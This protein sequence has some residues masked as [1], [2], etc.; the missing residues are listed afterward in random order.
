MYPT[1]AQHAELP[2]SL[3]LLKSPDWQTTI[4][5][6]PI[7]T[8]AVN[9]NLVILNG[10]P[11]A[12]ARRI[13]EGPAEVVWVVA[14]QA[15]DRAGEQVIVQRA[16]EEARKLTSYAP[17]A[18]SPV[19]NEPG[20]WNSLGVCTYEGLGA[21]GQSSVDRGMKLMTSP[22][23]FSETNKGF[24]PFAAPFVSRVPLSHR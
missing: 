4:A 12:N 21:A 9:N 19:M 6:Y 17:T 3:L 7:S 22:N 8:L 18:R 2:T 15:N 10:V 23:A 1:L 20:F 24:T 5:I 13:T 16:V 14:V 11:R